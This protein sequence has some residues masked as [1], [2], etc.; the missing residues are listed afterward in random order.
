MAEE[1]HGGCGSNGKVGYSIVDSLVVDMENDMGALELVTTAK[2]GMNNSQHLLDL[3]VVCSMAMWAP[4]RE[5]VGP[6][7]SP[8]TFGTTGVCVDVKDAALRGDETDVF[9]SI[10][11]VALHAMSRRAA[12]ERRRRENGVVNSDS[13]LYSPRMKARAVGMTCKANCRK[14]VSSSTS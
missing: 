2:D 14:P 12:L 10:A 9:H 4:D 7:E 13:K 8:K 1:S 6:K 11:K 5:P 3:D